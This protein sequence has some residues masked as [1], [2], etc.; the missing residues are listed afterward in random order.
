MK[1]TFEIRSR[2]RAND[3][4]LI[5]LSDLSAAAN[6]AGL[7]HRVIGGQ[8]VDLLLHYTGTHGQVIDRATADADVGVAQTAITAEQL[9]AFADALADRD[10]GQVAGDRFQRTHDRAIIDVLAAAVRTRRTTARLGPI[11]ATEAGGLAFALGQPPLKV[12]VLAQLTDGSALDPFE[13]QLPQL[14]A[15]VAIKAHAWADRRHRNDAIDIARLLHA[16]EAAQL[17]PDDFAESVSLREAVAHLRRG[18][19]TAASD[20][21]RLVYD[22][23][24]LRA[25]L[26]TM[27]VAV[28]G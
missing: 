21:V 9:Q 24:R 3:I 17:G 19:R 25:E 23:P 14:R 27:C 26:A 8:M 6:S 2:S 13:V 22:D 28:V 18:F 15:A 1:A 10:Y 20:G 7:R 5:A 16:A 12:T 11:V 4:S